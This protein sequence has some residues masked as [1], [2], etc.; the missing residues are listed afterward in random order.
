L[1]KIDKIEKLIKDYMI[2]EYEYLGGCGCCAGD[3]KGEDFSELATTI[4]KLL[5]IKEGT[6]GK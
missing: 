1:K 5:K 4:M 3:V 2:K 6:S